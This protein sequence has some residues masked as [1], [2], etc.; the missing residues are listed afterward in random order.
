MK[1]TEQYLR[2]L[3]KDTIV[4]LDEAQAAKWIARLLLTCPQYP[5]G[6]KQ[7]PPQG[8]GLSDTIIDSVLRTFEHEKLI[9]TERVKTEGKGRSRKM[10]TAVEPFT[11]LRELA[12]FQTPVALV[13]QPLIEV[14]DDVEA[15]Y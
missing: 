12:N 10:C 15:H 8:C 11:R 3:A 13:P 7:N 6:I 9:T 2:D 4:Y 14:L 5:S 1:S